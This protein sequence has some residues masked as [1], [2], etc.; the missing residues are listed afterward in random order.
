MG[1]EVE[2]LA[3]FPDS[4]QAEALLESVATK[5]LPPELFELVEEYEELSQSRPRF[6]WRWVHTL[7]PEFTFSFVPEDKRE[8]IHRI[9]TTT[10]LFIT[11]LDDLL[12][13]EGDRVTY[14][15]AAKVPL[16]NH[17]TDF[18]R[19]GI[20]SEHLRMTSRVWDE[21]R[22]TLAEAP[23]SEELWSVFEFDLKQAMAA[24]E[25]SYFVNTNPE[26]ATYDELVLYDSNNMMH[27]P[28]L[29]M[30]L[31]YADSLPDEELSTLRRAVFQAQRMARIGNW[32]M[33][34]ER[35]LNEGDISSGVVLCALEDDVISIDDI[36]RAKAQN[37]SNARQVVIDQIEDAGIEQHLLTQWHQHHNSL[38]ELTEQFE[39]ID[40]TSYANGTET[41]LRHH[42]A[43][44]GRL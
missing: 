42:L 34:W 21:I 4:E 11:L 20:R 30:D 6:M 28:Y 27:F 2:K 44:K 38:V 22:Q 8:E 26:L 7:A 41:I 43:A 9:K 29:D 12:E 10:T 32:I 33:T 35:E 13:R 15:E 16:S 5:E 3:G 24:I 31:M 25:Y 37:G 19:E 14:E 23:H 39:T 1:A 17:A 36:Q 18:N 40:I